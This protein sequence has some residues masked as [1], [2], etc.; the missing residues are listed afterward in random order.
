MPK[1][2]VAVMSCWNCEFNGDNQSLRTTW[3]KDLPTDVDYRFFI[4][5]NILECPEPDMVELDVSDD[6]PGLLLKSKA[7]HTWGYDQGYDYV[8]KADTDTFVDVA[9]LLASDFHKHDYSG[10]LHTE[11]GAYP[12][13][14]YGLLGG[15][16]GYWTSRKACSIIK[17][18]APS[19][20]EDVNFGGAEDLW[21]ANV[22]GAAGIQMVGLPGYG[23]GITLHGGVVTNAPRGSYDHA[24]MYDEYAKRTV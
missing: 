14:P 19:N 15:G 16:E 24:W 6:Y 11:P 8:F 1:I 5:R 13:T 17:D 2:L 9:A 23:R 3:L 7:L 18:A 20:S 22:L 10:Y 21:T 12:H 4:G